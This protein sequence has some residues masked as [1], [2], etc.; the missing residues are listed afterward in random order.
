MK[1]GDFVTWAG[2][3]FRIVDIWAGTKTEEG[4]ML[5]E[6]VQRDRF[7]WIPSPQVLNMTKVFP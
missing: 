1:I 2:K 5:L 7:R 4:A 3:L 6:D